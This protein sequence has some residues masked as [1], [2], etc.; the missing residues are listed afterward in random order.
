MLGCD[1]AFPE[2]ARVLMLRG[3]EL[4]LH[5]PG[6]MRQARWPQ[7]LLLPHSLVVQ[8]WS[9]FILILVLIQSVVVPVEATFD[10]VVIFYGPIEWASTT[11]FLLDFCL[12]FVFSTTNEHEK[13]IVD[14]SLIA[15][16]YAFSKWFWLDLASC[17]PFDIIARAAGGDG[18]VVQNTGLIKGLK[19]LRLFR[20]SKIMKKLEK[21]TQGGVQFTK[22][23]FGV[24]LSVHWIACGW[25]GVDDVW[26]CGADNVYEW[27]ADYD[28]SDASDPTDPRRHVFSRM[29]RK[30]RAASFYTSYSSCIHQACVTINGD[31]RAVT[32][33]EQYYFAFVVIYGSI[34]QAAI[35]G[36]MAGL[37]HRLD[38]ATQTY[39]TKMITIQ[40]R[41]AHLGLHHE[42]QDRI[43]RYYEQLWETDHAI[44]P[45]THEFFKE[46]TPRLHLDARLAIYANLIKRIPF[47]QRITRNMLEHLVMQ[48]QP[49][50]FME[51]E[52]MMRKND[53]GD[54]MAFV[55]QGMLAIL[56][57]RET[58]SKILKLLH[59]GDHVGERGLLDRTP[60][61]ATVIALVWTNVNV[62][63]REDWERTKA[64]FPVEAERVRQDLI[65]H[66]HGRKK[67]PRDSAPIVRTNSIIN[68][69]AKS[70]A[71]APTLRTLMAHKSQARSP[72][73]RGKV[74]HADGLGA[75]E[76]KADGASPNRTG[77]RRI[78]P[79]LGLA[80]PGAP[81]SGLG[82]TP[83]IG[84]ARA[85]AAA[86]PT[87]VPA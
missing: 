26:R 27:P 29:N 63:T 6:C 69:F 8:N 30:C 24:L 9:L 62:L 85:R 41:V 20:L 33:R 35:F 25:K 15:R 64:A 54:W 16:R 78:V 22:L 71:A 36:K 11:A 10:D 44:T 60:R 74:H 87:P 45:N 37:L 57:P 65:S 59:A 68:R 67:S 23:L 12:Q 80:A 86:K 43:L 38:E 47:M 58:R 48:M 31:G 84:A 76:A 50:I 28:A 72:N 56:D 55:E 73:S 2:V 53:M 14:G 42:L 32:I 49:Q 75:E 46:L 13:I 81:A 51:S 7:L 19:L 61:S 82:P 5:L 70:I 77:K 3:T 40:K 34:M 79:Q 52:S 66:A 83:V 39:Q 1:V 21:R 18:F 4:L 17:V